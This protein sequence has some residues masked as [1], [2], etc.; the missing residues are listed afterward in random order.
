MQEACLGAGIEVDRQRAVILPRDS[1]PP[2]LAHDAADAKSLALEAGLV[3]FREIPRVRDATPFGIERKAL[4]ISLPGGR[5]PVTP[6]FGHD[7][8]PGPGQID[9]RDGPRCSRWSRRGSLS[10]C[11][12]IRTRQTDREHERKG[13]NPFCNPA[14]LQFC[15]SHIISSD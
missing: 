10:L 11:G 8:D 1:Q 13:D 9:G 14:I 2:G 15:N 12:G 6:V 7:G 4:E 5:H 3:V